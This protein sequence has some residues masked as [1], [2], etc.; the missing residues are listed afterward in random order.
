MRE[1]TR[2]RPPAR[3]G[4][5]APR[6][7]RRARRRLPLGPRGRVVAALLALLVIVVGVGVTLDARGA[8]DDAPARVE[9]EG[10][11]VSGLSPEEVE[12]AVRYR[13]QQLMARPLTIVR[14]DVPDRPVRVSRASLG[15]R[16]QIRRAVDEALEP[17]GL[18]GRVLAGLASMHLLMHPWA[19]TPAG[20]GTPRTSPAG[21]RA[22]PPAPGS[23]PR[24]SP[25]RTRG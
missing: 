11:D 16:P 7:R 13:A 3:G 9:V 14:E 19:L 17:R 21:P 5:T 22:T 23:R 4:R 15:A 24:I 20:R 1:A 18:G 25:R 6:P 2:S 8:D 12:R 10:V